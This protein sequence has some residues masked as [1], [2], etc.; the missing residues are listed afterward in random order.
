MHR[1]AQIEKELLTIVFACQKFQNF[2]YGFNTKV[3]TDH[4]P[5]EIIFNKPLCLVPPRLQRMLLRLQKYDLSVK[6]VHGKFLY[7][8]DTLSRA[9]LADTPESHDKEIE[10]AI[11]QYTAPPHFRCEER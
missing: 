6:Y 7:I 8:A 10:L 3:Q 4:K 9:H 1:E 2:I 11:H 5:L